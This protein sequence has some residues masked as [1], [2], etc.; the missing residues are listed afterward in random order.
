MSDLMID[1]ETLS[2]DSNAIILTIG[3]VKFNRD[4]HISNLND[5]DTFYRRINIDS[6]KELGLH[7][8]NNTLNWWNLQNNET[9]YEALLNPDRQNLKFV[10][11][12]FSKWCK[13][14]KYF[15]GHGDDFD[16][17]ILSNAYKVCQLKVPWKFWNTRDTRTLFDIAHFNINDIP[18]E[19]AHHAL[20]DAYR[21]VKCVKL[22]L[23][24]LI[25]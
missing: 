22:A 5:C 2:T 11:E 13:N 15:W 19:E 7:E 20:H 25:H 18:V 23:K 21:Q 10:L 4:P 8:D 17:V 3:A 24:K 16:C 14:T 9:K 1:L 6:C 12:E